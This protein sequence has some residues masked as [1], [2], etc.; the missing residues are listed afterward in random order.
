MSVKIKNTKNAGE[1]EY[2]SYSK[3]ADYKAITLKKDG[4]VYV[5]HKALAD[6]LVKKK[7]AE[8]AK[9]VDFDIESRTFKHIEDVEK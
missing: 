1:V 2:I 8:Y 9:D 5:E 7:L 4:K 6:A 3:K